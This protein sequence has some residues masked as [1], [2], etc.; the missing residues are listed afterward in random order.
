MGGNC[1]LQLATLIYEVVEGGH[2]FASMDIP[3]A[4][5]A[6]APPSKVSAR[7]ADD[8]GPPAKRVRVAEEEEDA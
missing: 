8:D 3:D 5:P 7:D 2:G 1:T 6:E 4:T